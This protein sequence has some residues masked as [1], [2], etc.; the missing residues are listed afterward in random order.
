MYSFNFDAD[1]TWAIWPKKLSLL[2]FTSQRSSMIIKQVFR[3]F[4]DTVRD[5]LDTV[6]DG[7]LNHTSA[8]I[9]KINEL[10]TALNSYQKMVEVGDDFV[11]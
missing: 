1:E 8:L 10:E 11:R 3:H 4:F 2:E 7:I 9:D 6:K 5:K